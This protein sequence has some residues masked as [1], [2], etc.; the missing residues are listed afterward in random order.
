MVASLKQRLVRAAEGG[1]GFPTF[2]GVVGGVGF[3]GGGF[4]M[5]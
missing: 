5:A 2:Q 3:L 1:F 4:G